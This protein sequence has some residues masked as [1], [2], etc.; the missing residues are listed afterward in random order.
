M[1]ELTLSDG[2]RRDA[3]HLWRGLPRYSTDERWLVSHFEK[4]LYDQA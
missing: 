1:V 2:A 3:R 4:M